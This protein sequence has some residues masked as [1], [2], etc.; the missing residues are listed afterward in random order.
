[1]LAV[2]FHS[3]FPDRCKFLVFYCEALTFSALVRLMRGLLL[4]L[5]C[6]PLV[7]RQWSQ[8]IFSKNTGLKNMSGVNSH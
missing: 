8:Y 4:L 3:C 6:M 2:D 5:C 7:E 1:M